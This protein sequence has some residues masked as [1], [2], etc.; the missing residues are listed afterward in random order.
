MENFG[1]GFIEADFPIFSQ[2][3]KQY[4]F[5]MNDFIAVRNSECSRSSFK[6]I[7][8]VYTVLPVT[9]ADIAGYITCI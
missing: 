1:T 7:S 2:F 5:I 3:K 4:L 6:T 8:S 9:N